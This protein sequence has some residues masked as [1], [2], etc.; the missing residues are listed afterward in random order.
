MPKSIDKLMKAIKGDAL[1]VTTL[2]VY[3]AEKAVVAAARDL[4]PWLGDV[5]NLAVMQQDRP[6]RF[7]KAV[8]A[9]ER[10]KKRVP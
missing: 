6:K 7:V 1:R 8:E 5:L 10:M 9:L 4:A 3:E 2:G